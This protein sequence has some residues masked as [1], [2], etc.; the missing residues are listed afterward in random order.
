MKKSLLLCSVLFF[1]EATGFSIQRD[2][3][4]YIKGPGN[5][6]INGLRNDIMG[7]FNKVDGFDNIFKGHTNFG[8][9]NRNFVFG[10]KNNIL[11]SES[12]I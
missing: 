5:V 10:N 2:Q 9:G 11:G 7:A 4:N 12:I 1:N 3:P 8:K 6:V